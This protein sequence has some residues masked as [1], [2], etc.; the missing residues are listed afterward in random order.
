M[1][2]FLLPYDLN[3]FSSLFI[4]RILYITHITF[5]ICVNWLFVLPVRPLWSTVDL[6]VKFLGSEKFYVDFQL[7]DFWLRCSRV[8]CSFIF[9]PL[10]VPLPISSLC[11]P[12]PFPAFNWKTKYITLERKDGDINNTVASCVVLSLSLTV[13]DCKLPKNRYRI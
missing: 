6:V 1:N 5:K 11:T 8:S 13:D 3:I 7:C 2:V 10:Y 4:I 9:L 12:F